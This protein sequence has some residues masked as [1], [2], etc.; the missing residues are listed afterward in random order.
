MLVKKIEI[1][2]TDDLNIVVDKMNGLQKNAIA[3]INWEDRYPS[4]ANVSFKIAHNGEFV[5]LHFFVEEDEVLASVTEDN[6]EVWT[7][8]CVE[9][10]ISFGDSPYYYNAEFSCIGKGL[11]GYRK[12]RGNAIKADGKLLSSIKR[13]SSLG[14]KPFGRK[15]GTC[16]W[17]MIIAIPVTAYWQSDLGSFDG[18][19]ARANFYKCGDN[20][21]MP[22]FLSWSPVKTDN[23]N[24]HLP[25]FFDKLDFES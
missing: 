9:F 10:F 18:I 16:E 2:N 25:E 13:L 1:S 21:S 20:M 15:S 12:D 7:D 14:T 24:F 11:L 23:P 17:N 6:G 22:H 5:F 3:C 8:S 19:S 4:S